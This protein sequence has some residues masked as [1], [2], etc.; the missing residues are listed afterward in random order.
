MVRFCILGWRVLVA[1]P[2]TEDEEEKGSL[3]G[4]KGGGE[5]AAL[6]VTFLMHSLVCGYSKF[7]LSRSL[8]FQTTKEA[9]F[10]CVSVRGGASHAHTLLCAVPMLMR[11]GHM[12]TL[13]DAVVQ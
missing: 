13:T 9:V 10:V 11:M 12:L 3:V 2:T 6:K 4:R 1:D 8:S 5:K 7:A